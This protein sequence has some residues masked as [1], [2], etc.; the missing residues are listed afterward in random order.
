MREFWRGVATLGRGFAWWRRRPGLMAMGL[1]PAAVVAVV[2]AVGLLALG[3]AL[4]GLV[5][6]A[7]PFAEHWDGFWAV[8]LRVLIALA[9]LAGAIALAVTTFTAVVLLVGELVYQRIWQSVERDTGGAVPEARYSMRHAAGDALSL[10]LRG[11][12]IA[13]ASLLVGLV[14]VA[15]TAL[16]AVLG[17]CLTGW[18]L[19]DELT[20]RGLTA[21]GLGPAERRRLRRGAR[22]RMLGFG[23]ATQ[24]CFLVPGGAIAVMPAAVA[25]AALL[26]RE[27]AEPS[28]ARPPARRPSPRGR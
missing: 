6:W 9:V 14:P 24:L 2:F 10:V 8:A 1:A 26:A 3:F 12:A 7:T 16:A 5:E 23:V 15:G 11:A 22:A 27:L 21:R 20:Q 17:V 18:T 25:G 19:A 4:P 13:L 28:S